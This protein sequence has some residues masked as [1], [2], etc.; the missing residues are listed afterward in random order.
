LRATV[1]RVV[2]EN[3]ALRSAIADDPASQTA[4]R[5]YPRATSMRDSTALSA[6]HLLR[7]D[8]AGG[9]PRFRQEDD[10]GQIYGGGALI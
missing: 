4:Q 10:G 9:F 8:E 5:N 7:R 1:Q 2:V 6:L 3:G